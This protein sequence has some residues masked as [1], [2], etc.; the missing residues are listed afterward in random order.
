MSLS[1]RQE[2]IPGGWNQAALRDARVLVCGRTQAGASAIWGLNSL[3]IGEIL[4][5]GAE[6]PGSK[7]LV[8]WMLSHPPRLPGSEIYDYPAPIE[9]AAWLEWIA[10]D[11]AVQA[12]AICTDHP[13][14]RRLCVNFAERRGIPWIFGTA[15]S[16]GFLGHGKLH[17]GPAGRD[18]PVIGL[19]V[20]AQLVDA[21]RAL[22]SP[23]GNELSPQDGQFGMKAI[24]RPEPA[25]I[26][27]GG[28]GGIGVWSSFLL[29]RNGCE[30]WIADDDEVTETNLNRQ[31]LYSA[32]D[33][34]RRTKK[35]L[36]AQSALAKI[37]PGSR[38]HADARR[39]ATEYFAVLEKQPRQP[40]VLISAFDNAAARLAVSQAGERYGIPVVQGGTSTFSAD[41]FCQF[42]GGPTLDEQMH[43]ALSAAAQ[44]EANRAR[45]RGCTADPS[46]VVPSM[47]CGALVAYRTLQILNSPGQEFPP[48]RWRSGG[49]PAEPRSTLHD[50]DLADSL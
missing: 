2:I 10:G 40:R 46:Y 21:V 49:V 15:A 33:V 13:Q 30:L 24:Q 6:E 8:R 14:E 41:C 32:A 22:I 17:D 47:I 37:V 1:A 34:S 50:F 25:L 3:G 12:L 42:P 35:V 28:V 19:T 11:Q 20:G 45:R 31:S 44:R 36:A 29:A 9:Y 23:L 48:I 16:G 5:A 4:V 43:G 38:L 26:W 18:C 27:Q 39:V 7:S